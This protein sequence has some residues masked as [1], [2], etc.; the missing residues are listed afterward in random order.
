[1]GGRDDLYTLMR[2]VECGDLDGA[3]EPAGKSKSCVPNKLQSA[4]IRVQRVVANL[5][6]GARPFEPRRQT[7]AATRSVFPLSACS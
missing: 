6:G 7:L 3:G 5:P 1:M 4:A 2:R